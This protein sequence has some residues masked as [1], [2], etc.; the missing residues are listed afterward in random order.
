MLPSALRAF[1]L[2]FA[3]NETFTCGEVSGVVRIGLVNDSEKRTTSNNAMFIQQVKPMVTWQ[4]D[5]VPR[6]PLV[7]NRIEIEWKSEQTVVCISPSYD[8][9][10]GNHVDAC[11]ATLFWIYVVKIN[12]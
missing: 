7:E 8:S 3:L 2:G 10:Y 9:G 12:W 11:S 4:V 1:V 5:T 6:G